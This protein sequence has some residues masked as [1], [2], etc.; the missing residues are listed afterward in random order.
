MPFS[1][2]SPLHCLP[3]PQ[4]RARAPAGAQVLARVWG[5]RRRDQREGQAS[6]PGHR[7]GKGVQLRPGP[8][9]SQLPKGSKRLRVSPERARE[10]ERAL[11]V[12]A[13]RAEG[14]H[15]TPPKQLLMQLLFSFI[16]S[17]DV[18]TGIKG[19]YA[20]HQTFERFYSLVVREPWFG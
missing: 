2:G 12:L 20:T 9:S 16:F 10:S 1:W 13:P 3:H 4:E 19:K 17:A 7:Q 18:V 11:R 6:L 15:N 14:W 8:G 5:R